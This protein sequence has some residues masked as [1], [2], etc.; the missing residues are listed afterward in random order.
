VPG[1]GYRFIPTFS[2][3]GWRDAGGGA[4]DSRD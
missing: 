4:P 1:K 2:N 3:T